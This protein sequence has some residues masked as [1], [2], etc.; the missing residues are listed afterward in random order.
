LLFLLLFFL[1]NLL[2]LTRF[3]FV[4]SDESWLAGLTRA[5]MEDH[6]LAVTEP[7]FNLKPRWP[8]AVKSLFHLLQMPLI[9][10]FGY[11]IF[12]V[13]L[14]SLLGGCAVLIL[15]RSAVRRLSAGE[16]APL[17]ATILLACDI[18]FVYA[19]HFAR[20]EILICVSICACMYL[21]LRQDGMLPRQTVI[22]LGVI[23]GLSIGLH[24]NS[25]LI[26]C[27]CGSL[28]LARILVYKTASFRQL[29]L[30]TAIT[31]GF[32]AVFIAASF[33]MDPD[34]IRH[35][36]AYGDSEFDLLIPVTGK[37]AELGAF[38]QKLWYGV[39]GT[40]YLPD[41]KPQ[42]LLFPL[43][44]LCALAYAAV[45]RREDSVMSQRLAQ[46]VCAAAGILL[47]TVLIGRYNQTGIVF[48][49]PLCWMLFPFFCTMFGKITGRAVFA[50]IAAVVV[51]SSVQ[52]VR[53][54][55]SQ[56]Y[57]TYLGQIASLVAPDAKV[58]GNLNSGFYFANGCLLD[59]RNLSYLSENGL[60]FNDYIR[61]NGVDYL[62][63]SDE[64]DYIYSARPKWNTI[65]GNTAGYY[66]QMQTFI[67]NDCTEIGH[68]ENPY[69]GV[70]IQELVG[71]GKQDIIA[72]YRVNE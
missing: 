51:W 24:P 59:Y 7:F 58:L 68:F 12:S 14:L 41:I 36:L 61:Q 5:M 10:L 21:F 54:W 43:L 48:L 3:P 63:I 72:V 52:N 15:F 45:M 53:P 46:V 32:A 27:L 30:Y 49:M 4:H 60:R 11:R 1:I 65:Y 67:Q 28:F 22:A 40:Y 34:F 13:R 8:H 2:F 6:S 44:L 23:T 29:G 50:A 17:F 64:L 42:L 38:F 33:A 62:L 70:R 69:Y 56:S 19:S 9:A 66:E 57:E 35:Y 71:S 25:F 16:A 47:G 20:Q 37:A 39:S 55:L 18:Q 31:G 26:A